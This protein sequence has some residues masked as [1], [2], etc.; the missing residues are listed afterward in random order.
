MSS[1]M[2]AA[3]LLDHAP[4]FT[5]ESTSDSLLDWYSK[6]SSMQVCAAKGPCYIRLMQ[7]VSMGQ[8]SAA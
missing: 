5:S 7:Y 6:A 4:E 8:Q 2:H 3:T 1:W